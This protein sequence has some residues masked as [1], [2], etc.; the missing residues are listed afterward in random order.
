MKPSVAIVAP[1]NMGAGLARALG[2]HG[3][4]VLTS[5]E[6]RSAAT[7]ARAQTAGMR[8]VSLAGLT[9]A[10]LLLSVMPPAQALPFARQMAPLLEIASRKPLFVDCNAKS[11]QTARE[12]G[13]VLASCGTPFADGAIIGLPPQP[14]R[15]GPHLYAS[16][17]DAKGLTQLARYGLDIR[18]LEGPIGAAAALKM[19]FAGINKGLTL[20]AST[21]ILAATRSG[22]APALLQEL[23]ESC[24]EVLGSLS[25]QVPDML[26]KAYRWVAEMHEI[27]G[28]AGDDAAARQIY[29]GAAELCERIARDFAGERQESSALTGFFP[30]RR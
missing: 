4:E 17:D 12:L 11:P 7:C 20:V 10:D 8:A 14:G 2:E 16:G 24:P 3:I 9:E 19:C 6:G 5:L 29:Q 26:P 21:M 25:R 13:A 1:G 27:A 28:F 18:V 23:T 22:A 15:T 30:A